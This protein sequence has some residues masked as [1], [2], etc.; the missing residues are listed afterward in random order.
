MLAIDGTENLA[1]GNVSTS[2]ITSSGVLLDE[3]GKIPNSYVNYSGN[4][5]L[6]VWNASTNTPTITSG[7]GTNGQYYIVQVA[8]NTTI[9][10]N[11]NWGI[12]DYIIF[13]GTKHNKVDNP[14][15]VISVAG[16][17]G[18]V[19][20]SS[21]DITD[22]QTAVSSN[23]NITNNSTSITTLQTEQTTQ[24]TNIT[25]NS[26]S[27][28]TLQTEQTTQN[29][30]INTLQNKT[31]HITADATSTTFLN[32][33]IN[34]I[35]P[36]T[37]TE[38][39]NKNYVDT[40]ILN[41]PAVKYIGQYD[42]STNTPDLING[43]KNQGDY[44]VVSTYGSQVDNINS[45]IDPVTGTIAKED[46]FMNDHLIYNDKWVHIYGTDAIKGLNEGIQPKIKYQYT[47]DTP[48][49]QTIY[50]SDIK[51]ET[52]TYNISNFDNITGKNI[53]G[54]VKVQTPAVET[55]D[56]KNQDAT[57]VNAINIGTGATANITFQGSSYADTNDNRIPI[58]DGAGLISKTNAVCNPNGSIECKD[59][60]T[61]E[62]KTTFVKA[63]EIETS[64]VTKI[65]V[66]VAGDRDGTHCAITP[67]G[68]HIVVGVSRFLGSF[69][70]GFRVYHKPS[71]KWEEKGSGFS[72]TTGGENGRFVGI[73]D[74]GK[75][76]FCGGLGNGHVAVYNETTNSW[77]NELTVVGETRY[78][79]HLSG[80]GNT[81]ALSASN[82]TEFLTSQG[83]V[84]VYKRVGGVW[85]KQNFDGGDDKLLGS[86][87]QTQLV[88]IGTS[89]DGNKIIV[90]APGEDAGFKGSVHIYEFFGGVYT[91]TLTI[92]NTTPDEILWGFG[93]GHACSA[94][95]NVFAFRQRTPTGAIDPNVFPGYNDIGARIFRWN[96]SSWDQHVIQ[97]TDFNYRNLA[98]SP[99]GDYILTGASALSSSK[100]F[101]YNG[102]T[103]TEVPDVTY[104]PF[105]HGVDL[106]SNADVVATSQSS[107]GLYIHEP[108][109]PPDF[110]LHTSNN[111]NNPSHGVELKPTGALK[112]TSST[113]SGAE[114]NGKF[115]K[116]N[117]D[118][119]TLVAS[120]LPVSGDV[121]S[122]VTSSIA[123]QIPIFPD[124][125]GKIISTSSLTFDNVTKEL[126]GLERMNFSD[127]QFIAIG[128]NIRE[129]VVS[130]LSVTTYPNI[131][132]G[133]LSGGG[134]PN[135]SD[136][137]KL[138]G[139]EGNNNVYFGYRAGRYH[140]KGSF[141]CFIGAD[142]GIDDTET[143][144]TEY[145]NGIALGFST[146]IKRNNECVLGKTIGVST[147]LY[148]IR[149]GLDD[150]CNLG[151]YDTVGTDHFQFK[152]LYLTGDV[153]QNG[154]RYLKGINT[155]NIDGLNDI[156]VSFTGDDYQSKNGYL[157][158]LD[159]AGKIVPQLPNGPTEFVYDLTIGSTTFDAIHDNFFS[160][161]TEARVAVKKIGN[162]YF[163]EFKIRYTQSSSASGFFKIR[164]VTTRT[165]EHH[166]FLTNT[167]V[168]DKKYADVI[169]YNQ[170]GHIRCEY[171]VDEKKD[172][173]NLI[174]TGNLQL[175]GFDENSLPNGW[176]LV[177]QNAMSINLNGDIQGNNIDIT[178][179][180]YRNGVEL[181]VG[182]D[183]QGTTTSNTNE[184]P[185]FVGSTGKQ[186]KNSGVTITDTNDISGVKDMNFTGNLYQNGNLFTGGG[187][188]GGNSVCY[189][190]SIGTSSTAMIDANYNNITNQSR[191]IYTEI[192][193]AKFLEFFIS[194]T[195][196][197]TSA[198]TGTQ[199]GTQTI[200]PVDNFNNTGNPY[201]GTNF[202][203]YDSGGASGT[204]PGSV[205]ENFV[206]AFDGG[207]NPNTNS[208]TW[209]IVVNTMNITVNNTTIYDYLG[210]QTS[211]DGVNYS[212]VNLNGLYSGSNPN[213]TT[214][215]AD[216]VTS[217][218]SG[219]LFNNNIATQTFNVVSRYIRFI[220]FDYNNPANG[221][222]MSLTSD[223]QFSSNAQ[224]A[225]NN[226][227]TT[228]NTNYPIHNGSVSNSGSNLNITF[229]G[230]ITDVNM[231]G[232]IPITTTIDPNNLPTGWNSVA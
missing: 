181:S 183:V 172:Y 138:L 189:D 192:G 8:G 152:N 190:L 108:A 117:D 55:V 4:S 123:T 86:R 104:G 205:S 15:A 180:I 156:E 214:N 200:I 208:T 132:V 118:V 122:N 153:F 187:G 9:D 179:N 43:T 40:S 229:D 197:S 161:A 176:S 150:R 211:N 175:N 76:V 154:I 47:L 53:I 12:G 27:I 32:K 84:T 102:T 23:T 167:D 42:A 125:T 6:G 96:G 11:T 106:S 105:P 39:V 171:E 196:T 5:F 133:Y 31:Q 75:T 3:N 24:N 182:G 69:G 228:S 100:L 33:I 114:N 68:K 52:S 210:L 7:V 198:P 177:A 184:I 56:I 16:K 70:G 168:T 66:G 97:Y 220:W 61:D 222:D 92:S 120:D 202:R 147:D 169:C 98:I 159:N 18:S 158:T 67:D 221:W 80:D 148:T 232:K 88:C 50:Q 139:V 87:I 227:N 71:T 77:D 195:R 129:P 142:A 36:T 111:S 14:D 188:G 136:S 59:I 35:T 209:T 128:G 145:K 194:Y 38:L 93:Y 46:Y 85:T 174:F 103:Y 223:G 64:W 146:K 193:S 130:G 143:N 78:Y 49:Q 25:N 164:N 79:S 91:K 134:E 57:P 213:R 26:T 13:D 165:G 151:Y 34:N 215:S 81:L 124:T 199:T 173:T 166:L 110:K 94:D 163:G 74:D 45:T 90:G 10:G 73:S 141:S 116:I 218:T 28:T 62:I 17:I 95:C 155:N 107:I 109:T 144:T 113:Y 137:S 135:P 224:L 22:F 160:S 201:V 2:G 119:G 83:M 60:Y 131:A 1:L 44:Y 30:N 58:I 126:G 206:V 115:L 20:L 203:F 149:H 186:L 207:V 226:I 63:N 37:G 212:N 48:T 29:T 178:G 170:N 231:S 72:A 89:T 21:N 54:N 127:N 19:V 230:V 99:E 112:L 51:A 101:S 157:L 140:N 121:S 204:I 225:I 162:L 219:W 191:V 185:R 82:H 65:T 216:S 41:N 217:T